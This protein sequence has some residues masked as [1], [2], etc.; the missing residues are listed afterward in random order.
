VRTRFGRCS[1]PAD[2]KPPRTVQPDLRPWPTVAVE[3]PASRPEDRATACTLISASCTTSWFDWIHGELWLCPTGLL[4]RSLGLTTTLGHGTGNR[5]TVDPAH[6]PTRTFGLDEIRQILAEGRR[7]RWISWSEISQAT[8]K[9]GLMDSSLHLELGD[10]R[11]EKF[12]WLRGDGGYDLLERSLARSLPGR[13][14]AVDK[15]F[16]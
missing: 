1:D 3:Q 12:L 8:L 7:N 16:G 2:V 10:R 14:K 13:F 9:R 11:R 6:R 5:A 4:R 15:A